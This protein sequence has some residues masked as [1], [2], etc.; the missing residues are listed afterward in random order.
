MWRSSHRRVGPGA[1]GFRELLQRL[2]DVVRALFDLPRSPL[3]ARLVHEVAAVDMDGRRQTV[4]RVGHRVHGVGAEEGD[5]TG[6]ELLASGLDQG[7]RRRAA[8]T[9]EGVVLLAS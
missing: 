3:A 9:V 6:R 4:L 5:L 7:R 8:T 1:I 2:V